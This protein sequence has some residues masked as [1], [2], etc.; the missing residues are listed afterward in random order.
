MY[1]LSDNQYLVFF[2][3]K[4]F[5]T[6]T[7][8]GRQSN[9]VKRNTLIQYLNNGMDVALFPKLG[10][11]GESDD[12][13]GKVDKL[14]K[15]NDS[16]EPAVPPD[17]IPIKQEKEMDESYGRHV[18]NNSDNPP[19]LHCMKSSSSAYNDDFHSPPANS[20]SHENNRGAGKDLLHLDSL[21]GNFV[22]RGPP[23]R[24]QVPD[25]LSHNGTQ[26]D[27]FSLDSVNDLNRDESG[28]LDSQRPFPWN[29]EKTMSVLNNVG[30]Q[31]TA[32]RNLEHYLDN[33]G[34]RDAARKSQGAPKRKLSISEAIEHSSAAKQQEL[35]LPSPREQMSSEAS[36]VVRAGYSSSMGRMR[37]GSTEGNNTIDNSRQPVCVY[38]SF[39]SPLSDCS[40]C[41]DTSKDVATCA[42]E[43]SYPNRHSLVQSF[44]DIVPDNLVDHTLPRT[45][46]YDP[47]KLEGG[48]TKGLGRMVLSPVMTQEEKKLLDYGG[49]AFVSVLIVLFHEIFTVGVFFL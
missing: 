24:G 32:N 35:E 38:E 34:G 9:S 4:I 43:G 10:S 17:L 21:G 15:N 27:M 23:V 20:S 5:I 39:G 42:I 29:V 28:E 7:R 3:K 48:N 36:G 18:P 1:N 22:P 19:Q 11:E 6:G 33:N 47:K 16:N 8:L 41:L 26:M 25:V 30:S 31:N 46:A 45:K 14:L 49:N 40:T 2:L 44:R 37:T 13:H 12:A